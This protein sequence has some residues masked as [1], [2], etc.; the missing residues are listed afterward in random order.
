MAQ[1]GWVFLDDR[2]G[3]HRVG[4]YHGDRTGHLVI[5]CNTRVVQIDFSVKETKM[6]SFFIEDELCE[7]SVVKEKDGSFG[8]DFQ[9]NKK[10]DTPRNRIRRVDERRI[11]KQMA[12]FITGFVVVAALGALGLMWLGRRETDK[13]LETTTLFSHL[14]TENARRLATEGK[15]GTA[16]LFIVQEATQRKV[17]YGFTT[18]D[19][20][21]ISGLYPA[22][23]KAPIILPNGFPLTDRDAFS[24][25]YLPADPQVHR[26]DFYQ[27]AR[28]T[29]ERYV[30]LAAEA[31]RN[32]HPDASE[33]HSIC[34]ALSAAEFK[35][36]LSLADFIY[37][38]E[39]PEENEQHNR[40]SYLRLV[41]DVG[42]SKKVREECWDQ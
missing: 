27:P 40:E 22:P 17:Y 34:V 33:K 13:R 8:Y 23:D 32:A 41:R 14:S 35:G 16:E 36:W 10:V 12:L 1:M 31:E 24:V 9:V 21:R 3:R 4:L 19:S 30:H 25:S 38:S 5:H 39:S 6:Y 2:G 37:Q 20:I 28:A 26:V 42:F 29:I 15:T 7:I 18:A 11:R